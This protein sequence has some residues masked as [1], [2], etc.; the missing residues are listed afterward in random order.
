MGARRASIGL[1]FVTGRDPDF[2]VELVGD[3]FVPAPDYVVGDVGT[4]IAQFDASV[5]PIAELE[6]DIAE[7]WGDKAEELQTGLARFDAL[8]LQP[9]AFR[10]RLSYDLDIARYDPDAARFAES[11]GYDALVSADR[12]FDVLPRG[13]SK[14]PS[15]MRLIHFLDTNPASVLVAGDTLNDLSLFETGLKGVVVG[16]AEGAL[17]DGTQGRAHIHHAQGVG[18]AGILEAIAHSDLDPHQTEG[19]MP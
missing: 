6:A 12:F 8:T 10:Y 1:I 5:Q 4:T 17:I 9:T 3:G 13:V 14:G 18:A 19:A 11:L 2:I 16:G 7:R 15:L